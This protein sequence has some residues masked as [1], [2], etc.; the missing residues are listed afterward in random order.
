MPRLYVHKIPVHSTLVNS[1]SYRLRPV[2]FQEQLMVVQRYGDSHPLTSIHIFLL[3]GL[4]WLDY[5]G[6]HSCPSTD[7]LVDFTMKWKV[8]LGFAK[9]LGREKRGREIANILGLVSVGQGPL[10]S[11][12]AWIV[13]LGTYWRLIRLSFL[14][15]WN[16]CWLFLNFWGESQGLQG[17]RGRKGK[18][19]K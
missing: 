9:N 11:I 1:F 5:R 3:H 7:P 8:Y 19:Y 16:T 10:L 4:M 15:L 14:I 2:L 13:L 6:S 18:H 17:Y 12:H